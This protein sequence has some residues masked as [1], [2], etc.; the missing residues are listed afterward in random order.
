M[1]IAISN[2][3]ESP[4]SEYVTFSVDMTVISS[5]SSET[6]ASSSSEHPVFVTP[7]A[8]LSNIQ[9][10]V[11][12]G[13]IY[14]HAPQQGQKTVRLFSPIGALLFEATMDGHELEIEN[15]R[16]IQGINAFLS[17]TQGRKRLFSG[18]VF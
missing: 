17:V 8:P 12:H 18:K 1:K 11:H 9:V 7:P 15:M 3:T 14:I 16:Q 10:R 4:D 2:I 6:V 13:R 5:S